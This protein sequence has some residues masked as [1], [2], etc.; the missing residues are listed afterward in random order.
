MTQPRPLPEW[1]AL[2]HLRPEAEDRW[3]SEISLGFVATTAP[4]SRRS[5]AAPPDPSPPDLEDGDG[6]TDAFFLGVVATGPEGRQESRPVQRL[7]I[8]C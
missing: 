6:D 7:K 2:D 5:P 4:R 3:D 8:R 1:V